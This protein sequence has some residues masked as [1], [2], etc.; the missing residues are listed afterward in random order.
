MKTIM[1]LL[2]LD[3]TKET[4]HAVDDWGSVPLHYASDEKHG[5]GHIVSL[6]IEAEDEFARFWKSSTSNQIKNRRSIMRNTVLESSDPNHAKPSDFPP[7]YGIYHKLFYT[8]R[9]RPCSYKLDNENKSPLFHAVASESGSDT[10][11]PLLTPGYLCLKCFDSLAVELADVLQTEGNEGLRGHIIDELSKR[12]YFCL[13]FMDIYVH[14]VALIAY[15]ISTE[16][17]FSGK[18]QIYEVLVIWVCIAVNFI[19]ECIRFKAQT[20]SYFFDYCETHRRLV[21]IITYLL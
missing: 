20:T 13:M 15:V 8:Y 11:Q 14:A 21:F 18:L 5:N 6:L 4:T 9:S 1:Q 17:F 10:I 3:Y 7:A 12:R 19:R 16:D 2:D